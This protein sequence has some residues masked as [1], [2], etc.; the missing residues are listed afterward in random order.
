MVSHPPT[1][2]G[3]EKDMTASIVPADL[4][5]L[6]KKHDASLVA[7]LLAQV[8]AAAAI[9]KRGTNVELRKAAH[10][11]NLA[12]NNKIALAEVGDELKQL[13]PRGKRI[14]KKSDAIMDTGLSAEDAVEAMQ[15]YL[16][17]KLINEA[18]T[19]IQELIKTLVFRHMDLCAA[20]Q[21]E[22]F[23][24]QTN[25]VIDVPET[26]K[27]FCREGA[28]RKDASFDL[29]K[30]REVVGDEVFESITIERVTVTREVNEA[31]LSVAANANPALMELLR[32]AVVPGDWKSPR[33]SIRDIPANE[34]E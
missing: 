1:D 3:N 22:T 19:A 32:E 16:G 28:G 11:K 8:D 14:A 29:D 6:L 9:E 26:G 20:E 33:L 25:M 5:A 7:D 21:G 24:E 4:A 17:G 27:R 12:E 10:R 15:A 13:L 31:A 30:L 2:E 23:P 34:K 18:Q